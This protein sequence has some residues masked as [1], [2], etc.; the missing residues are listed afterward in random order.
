[1][2]L[3]AW[4]PV[5]PSIDNSAKQHREN[6]TSKDGQGRLNIVIRMQ[7]SPSCMQQKLLLY[8][9]IRK[10]FFVPGYPPVSRANMP[11]QLLSR[12]WQS[13]PSRS[14]SWPGFR[15]FRSQTTIFTVDI[16]YAKKFSCDVDSNKYP[17]KTDCFSNMSNGFLFLINYIIILNDFC[18]LPLP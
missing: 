16:T 2:F 6:E 18:L 11:M 7:R 9:A 8:V 12:H 15:L 3:G 17:P 10:N 14:S 13:P 5:L 4:L 1:M